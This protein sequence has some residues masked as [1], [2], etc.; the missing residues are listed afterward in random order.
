MSMRRPLQS[1]FR[2]GA[3]Q[4]IRYNSTAPSLESSR[5]YCQNLLKK[6]DYP[7]YLQIPFIPQ[8]CRDAH[9]AICAL[10]IEMAIIPEMVSNLHARKMRMQFWKD[11][12]EDCF[13]GHPKAEPVSILLAQVLSSGTRLSKSF[14]Q[15]IISER[16]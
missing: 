9:L 16:V 2:V 13:Q 8:I 12:V 14:F 4:C 3:G 6:H 7:S 1:I 5:I 10:N 15:T 11:S